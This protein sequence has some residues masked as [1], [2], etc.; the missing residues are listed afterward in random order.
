MLRPAAGSFT[1]NIKAGWEIPQNRQIHIPQ[2]PGGK[3]DGG[4]H[5]PSSANS[6]GMGNRP[7]A[8][9]PH[10]FCADFGSERMGKPHFPAVSHP[11]LTSEASKRDGK[12]REYG[13]FTS[14]TPLPDPQKGCGIK[15]KRW[16]PLLRFQRRDGKADISRCFTSFLPGL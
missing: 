8:A 3:L 10:P 1:E 15:E 16:F 2:N 9:V 5:F 4:S 14:L 7:D 12:V 11:F 13:S 6:A